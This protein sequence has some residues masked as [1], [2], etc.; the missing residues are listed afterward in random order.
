[1][2][3]LYHHRT[4]SRD[5]Q[6]LHVTAIISA[7]K[8][9]GHS[10]AVV[11]PG[12]GTGSDLGGGGAFVAAVRKSLPGAL[13]E[14]MEFSYNLLAYF[15]LISAARVAKPDVIYERYNLFLVAGI[16]VKRKLGIPLLLEVNAPLF[17]ERSRHG[18]LSLRKLAK[19]SEEYCWRHADHVLPV[20]EVLARKVR[21]AGVPKERITVI[22]NGV[23]PESFS[24][25]QTPAAVR[26]SLGL[27]EN[28]V[29]GFVGFIR[30]WHGL[31]SV[32]S[33]L[34]GPTQS[35]V[36]LLIV[37]DG[38]GRE[39]IEEEAQSLGVADR[40]VITGV[41]DRARVPDLVRCF[42]IALQPAV[43]PYAS[44]LKMFEYM[45]LGKA[46]VA[47]N[48]ENIREILTDK[49]NALL[50]APG[51]VSE[52]TEKV[53]SLC[54]HA[55]LRKQLGHSA[56]ERISQAGYTWQENAVKIARIAGELS[57]SGSRS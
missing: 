16:W 18:G 36:T 51:N 35:A 1:M 8:S 31:K 47:P 5:G 25:R 4:A 40:V 19:W 27:G 38:P 46:I 12:A 48:E 22:H 45:V 32:L 6:F 9:T 23:D 42:D 53:K 2:N 54:E 52:F 14:I 33:V 39:E 57:A 15:R 11:G 55:E 43:V 17:E 26:E 49:E 13:S 7:L 3:F 50:F 20:T 37:G 21:A 30:P 29:L 56:M 41:V 10:V 44:P 24:E 28:L 34:A